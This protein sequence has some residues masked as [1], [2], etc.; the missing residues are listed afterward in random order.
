MSHAFPD[1]E[2]YT[3]WRDPGAV[4]AD[5]K[6]TESW[7][8][9]T[10]LRRR[11][12][13]AL[14]LMPHT[15]RTLH[16]AECYDWMLVSSHLF[17]HHARFRGV[18]RGIPKFV[19]AHTP[20][21]YIWTPELDMRG[22][23]P[24]ARAASAYYKSMDRRRATGPLA[25]AANSAYVQDRISRFWGREATVIHPPVSVEAIAESARTGDGLSDADRRVIDGLP[26]TFILGA[27]RFVSYKQLDKV[28]CVGGL[29]D[30]P[31][32][33]AGRGPEEHHLRGIAASVSVL[34]MFVISPSDALLHALYARSAAFVFPPV[35]DFGMMPVEAMAAGAPV[36]VNAVGGA[37][38]S[39]RRSAAGVVAHFSELSDVVDRTRELLD[40]GIR[41]TVDDVADFSEARFIERLRAWVAIELSCQRREAVG[42]DR[43]T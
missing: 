34:V 24:V 37:Q 15:W 32:V 4:M 9:R 41:P 19:Y 3:L 39:I 36:V 13:L 25:I 6:I 33:I 30:I 23:N 28:I 17:A 29:L 38:E 42:A 12:M 10:P 27:S 20:A 1:A 26:E 35:E 7:L 40:G 18:N 2:L 31:V 8:S 14:P 21:R 43:W 11:K 5:S 16:T 22:D